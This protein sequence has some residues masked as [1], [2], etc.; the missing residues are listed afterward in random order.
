VRRFSMGRGVSQFL[1][2]LAFLIMAFALVETIVVFFDSLAH[3]VKSA[4]S[5]L[6]PA[7]VL[8]I[9]NVH[10]DSSGVLRVNISNR[11]PQTVDLSLLDIVVSVNSTSVYLY[12]PCINVQVRCW[13]ISAIYVGPAQI[14]PRTYLVPGETV[15]AVL[16]LPQQL[17]PNT[18]LVIRALAGD[19]SA[20]EYSYLYG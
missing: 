2:L 4:A 3:S 18:W 8:I 20:A 1:G 6:K 10:A 12:R 19:G 7:G 5:S 13:S 9:A 14:N 11:G 17:Q 16:Q 15:E